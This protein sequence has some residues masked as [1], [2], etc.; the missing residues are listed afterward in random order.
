ME[1]QP[2]APA[3]AGG[4]PA[5]KQLCREGLGGPGG[6]QVSM[7]QHRVLVAKKASGILDAIGKHCQQDGG[8]DLVL[9]ISP[10]EAHLGCCVQFWAPQDKR[11]REPLK[12]VQQRATKMMNGLEHLVY[13]EGLQQLDLFSLKKGLHQ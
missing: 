10:G 4:S 2:Q 3:Q 9:L 7:R 11:D 1:E 13:E 5:G 12:W 6:E 8:C